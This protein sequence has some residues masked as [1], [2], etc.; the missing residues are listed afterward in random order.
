MGQALLASVLVVLRYLLVDV[1]STL[2]DPRGVGSR[3]RRGHGG[4]VRRLPVS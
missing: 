3:A 4:I 2:L 1:V